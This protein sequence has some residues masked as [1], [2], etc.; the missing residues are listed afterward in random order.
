MPKM[1]RKEIMFGLSLADFGSDQ[2][3]DEG[4]GGVDWEVMS[5]GK[6]LLVNFSIPPQDFA[7]YAKKPLPPLLDAR[8]SQD[9]TTHL[10]NYEKSPQDYKKIGDAAKVWFDKYM[11]RGLVEK[12]VYLIET[13]S[14][15]ETIEPLRLRFA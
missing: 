6:P 11:G 3:L 7:S 13:M 15:G 14:K 4:L 9:I 10:L 2:F 12:Y 5:L 8:T 1:S